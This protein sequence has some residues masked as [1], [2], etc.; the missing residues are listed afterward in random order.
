MR[1]RQ[2][3][4]APAAPTATMPA[5]HRTEP[6]GS[7][8]EAEIGDSRI[9][10]FLS[11]SHRA[12]SLG[13]VDRLRDA[14]GDPDGRFVFHSPD[15]RP[16]PAACSFRDRPFIV[17]VGQTAASPGP[18]QGNDVSDWVYT[19]QI[20]ITAWMG[21]API[22]R[23]GGEVAGLEIGE[24]DQSEFAQMAG[25]GSDEGILD[26]ADMIGVYLT[27]G[28]ETVNAMNAR[29][30]GFGT[31]TNGFIEPFHT[32]AIGACEDAQASHVHAE[33]QLTAGE[34]KKVIITV[35]GAR[36]IRPRGML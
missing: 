12:V 2:A 4:N 7:I 19:A 11:M 16:P 29:I 24:N 27:K 10:H 36:R 9:R 15:L 31:T 26:A 32:A 34:V 30:P 13:I 6:R 18:I 17:T 35:S 3:G 20:C 33:G 1:K 25:A 14:I 23:Q 8:P 22:D 28:Y 5:V 21:Y